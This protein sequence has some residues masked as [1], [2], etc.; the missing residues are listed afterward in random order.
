MP[1]DTRVVVPKPKPIDGKVIK[2]RHYNINY[3]SKR[4][5]RIFL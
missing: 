5:L 1:E 3:S 2:P 4:K